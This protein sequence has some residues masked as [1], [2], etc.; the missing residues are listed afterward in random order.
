MATQQLIR[1]SKGVV[2]CTLEHQPQKGIIYVNW[3]GFVND[4]EPS[5]QACLAIAE[6]IR[7]TDCRHVVNDNREQVGS[8]P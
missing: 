8:Q 2:F 4:I 3:K 6:M 7:A 5:K 1:N